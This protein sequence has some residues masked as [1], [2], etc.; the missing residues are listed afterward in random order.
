MKLLLEHGAIVTAGDLNPIPLEHSNL[1]FAITNVTSWEALSALFKHAIQHRLVIDHVFA[2]AGIGPKQNYLEETLDANGDLLEPSHQTYDVNLKSM[3]NTCA[4][5]LHYM[6][7]S[8]SDNNSIVITASVSS[9]VRFR[10]TDYTAAKHG[11][12]GF[13]RGMIP[14]LKDANIPIRINALAPGWTATGLVPQPF[15]EK[16]N[17]AWQPPS[18]VARSVALLMADKERNGQLIYSNEGNYKEIEE[19]ILLKAAPNLLGR[20]VEVDEGAQNMREITMQHRIEME[21]KAAES[22]R[23]GRSDSVLE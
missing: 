18:A 14:N 15:L 11:V 4:L 20:E 5:G 16:A 21:R 6:R 12:L 7:K 2:N 22:A 13:M 9:F 23:E 1:S 10:A 3:V 19:S 8:P 17:V